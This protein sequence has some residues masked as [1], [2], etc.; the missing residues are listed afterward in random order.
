MWFITSC[1]GRISHPNSTLATLLWLSKTSQTNSPN[2][3]VIRDEPFWFPFKRQN[4]Q[5]GRIFKNIQVGF[6]SITMYGEPSSDQTG[7]TQEVEYDWS[8]FGI[9]IVPKC[10]HLSEDKDWEWKTE[11]AS[12][13]SLLI[14][15]GGESRKTEEL[16]P[17]QPLS[18]LSVHIIPTARAPKT[19]S[20][21]AGGAP[22]PGFLTS[23]IWS[24]KVRRSFCRSSAISA[25]NGSAWMTPETLARSFSFSILALGIA[26]ENVSGWSELR[27]HTHGES[28]CPLPLTWI[29]LSMRLAVNWGIFGHYL[30]AILLYTWY[31]LTISCP[32]L[33]RKGARLHGTKPAFHTEG[34]GSQEY[35]KSILTL[36]QTIGSSVPVLSTFTGSSTLDK[37]SHKQLIEHGTFRLQRKCYATELWPVGYRRFQA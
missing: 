17:P 25:V 5:N 34:P 8:P 19:R 2:K 15:G 6:S 13:G 37:V 18:A 30:V 31:H 9:V 11:A 14:K 12:S 23:H 20:Q 16:P 28:F 24:W 29:V 35:S 33:R 4:K 26:K 7:T 1:L 21:Q 22:P 36:N 10:S 32:S 3:V 27:T